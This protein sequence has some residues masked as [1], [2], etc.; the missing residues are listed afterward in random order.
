MKYQRTSI[1][2]PAITLVFLSLSGAAVS[3]PISYNT[4]SAGSVSRSATKTLITLSLAPAFVANNSEGTDGPLSGLI[5]GS[6]GTVPDQAKIAEYMQMGKSME[7]SKI[8]ISI[9]LIDYGYTGTF[10]NVCI[11]VRGKNKERYEA[12][13]LGAKSRCIGTVTIERYTRFELKGTYSGG[14]TNLN[15]KPGYAKINSQVNN[16]FASGKP[17]NN[18]PVA[19]SIKGE[20]Y[21]LDP[22]R[23]D[24]R[25]SLDKDAFIDAAE[26]DLRG[27]VGENEDLEKAF[28]EVRSNQRQND[29]SA[30]QVGDVKACDC[31]CNYVASAAPDC[32]IKCGEAFAICT[33]ERYEPLQNT[34]ENKNTANSLPPNLSPEQALP[35]TNGAKLQ[36][37]D[38]NFVDELEKGEVKTPENLREK[39]ISMLQKNHPG[40]ENAP[41]RNMMIKGFDS[42]PDDKSKII[43]FKS[44]E[45]N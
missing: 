12:I 8:R 6:G 27:M 36:G 10:Y 15:F 21:I 40:D 45:E 18:P 37:I 34:V 30:S 11:K 2:K 7:K 44:M 32:K 5:E 42:M 19:G 14:L 17:I 1:I 24:S 25:F 9:P 3:E 20:F 31:S 43:M 33:A 38:Q 13:D 16:G 23:D 39:F 4:L 35:K 29:K 26:N 22:W 41:I 28:D